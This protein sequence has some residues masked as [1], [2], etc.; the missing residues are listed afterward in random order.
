MVSIK[1]FRGYRYS[2]KIKDLNDV[3]VPPYDVISERERINY[4]NRSEYNFTRLILQKEKNNYNKVSKMLN[5]WIDK[6]ILIRD[7][8]EAIYIYSSTY[9][10]HGKKCTRIGFISSLKLEELGQGILPHEKTMNKPF[11]DRL[12]LIEATKANLGQVFLIYDDREKKIDNFLNKIIES[13]KEEFSFLDNEK[14]VH[15]LWKII[16][17]EEIDF[18]CKQMQ[19]HQ[20]IIADGH[21]R[22][23]VSLEYAKRHPDIESAKYRMATFVNSF[24][25]DLTIYPVNRLIYNLEIKNLDEIFQKISEYFEI[26]EQKS[27]DKMIDKLKAT[28]VML[29]KNQNLKNHV[30][31]MYCNI[32]RKSYFLKLKDRSILDKYYKKKSDIYKKL[33]LNILHK[34]IFKKILKI[35]KKDQYKGQ[36]IDFVKGITETKERLKDQKYQFGFFVNA[37][38]MREIFLLSRSNETM[39]QK[40]T[41]FYPKIFSGT[42]VRKLE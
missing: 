35:S 7:K 38:L 40:S 36:K 12:N 8:E 28:P 39:P 32:N 18:I 37:I 23:K 24:Q 26:K 1:P 9:L 42:V 10:H 19:K 6:G 21:H 4:Y 16:D 27:I 33:D 15:K 25:D 13:K 14:V 29:D 41:Y 22:Y 20:C 30:F 5:D 11:K 3:I 34:I 31:G 2:N 17:K